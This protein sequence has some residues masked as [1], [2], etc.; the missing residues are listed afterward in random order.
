MG[1]VSKQFSIFFKNNSGNDSR[2][3]L[4]KTIWKEYFPRMTVF[5]RTMLDTEDSADA[6]Q[7]IM[8]KVLANL[9]SYNPL[10]SF[11]TWIYSIARHHCID[12]IRS[13]SRKKKR[14]IDLVR[15]IVSQT[16]EDPADGVLAGELIETVRQFLSQ[17]N[18][19]DRQIAYL[20][21]YEDLRLREIARITG[22]PTGTVKYRIHRIR[23]EMK[24][25]LEE[26]DE[27]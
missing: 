27:A 11:N 18:G 20:R 25:Y 3:E 4:F 24:K 17:R 6:V 15:D 1:T 26:R 5:T 13:S 16:A 2:K 12:M 8:M 19:S 7:E 14:Q 21:F 22:M 10:Y 9:S 23:G